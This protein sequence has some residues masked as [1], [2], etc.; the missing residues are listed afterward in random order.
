MVALG[1]DLTEISIL[2]SKLPNADILLF[3]FRILKYLKK[4]KVV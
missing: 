4:N 1:E 2:K 3:K